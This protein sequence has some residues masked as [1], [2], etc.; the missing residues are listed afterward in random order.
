MRALTIDKGIFLRGLVITL[1]WA[2]SPIFW[3]SSINP[4]YAAG[5]QA[6][7]NLGVVPSDWTTIPLTGGPDQKSSFYVTVPLVDGVDD[8]RLF[9]YSAGTPV[10]TLV[11]T[12]TSSLPL[13]EAPSPRLWIDANGN[14]VDNVMTKKFILESLPAGIEYNF[15]I[16]SIDPQG[17]QDSEII[18]RNVAPLMTRIR[19]RIESL[20]QSLANLGDIVVVNGSNLDWINRNQ[21]G[22]EDGIELITCIEYCEPEP[23]DDPILRYITIPLADFI[24][25]TSTKITFAL[26]NQLPAG[27]QP[28]ALWDVVA[29][30]WGASG[31]LSLTIGTSSGEILRTISVTSGPNGAVTPGTS[32]T[33]SDGSMALYTITPD[34]GYE[35]ASATLNGISILDSLTAVDGVSKSYTF[36]SVTRNHSLEATFRLPPENP[37][38]NLQDEMHG[39]YEY[40]GDGTSQLSFFQMRWAKAS[41]VL[42]YKVKVTPIGGTPEIYLFTSSEICSGNFCSARISGLS[43]GPDYRIEVA[44]VGGIGRS[45]S[46]YVSRLYNNDAY[47]SL[48]HTYFKPVNISISKLS[49]EPGDLVSITG[50]HLDLA[51]R[52]S[53]G[54]HTDESLNNSAC[55]V[56]EL[57]E[58][59]CAEFSIEASEFL[60]VSPNS[61]S[62]HIPSSFPSQLPTSTF[63]EGYALRTDGH[64]FFGRVSF[65]LTTSTPQENLPTTHTITVNPGLHGSISPITSSLI[66]DGSTPTYTI[67]PENGYVIDSVTVNSSPISLVTVSGNIKSYTFESVTADQVIEAFF[68]VQEDTVITPPEIN[69]SVSVETAT[70]GTIT[71]GTLASIAPG[72][73]RTFT[74]TPNTGYRINTATLDGNNIVD[75]L[76]LVSGE[77]KS[78]TFDSINANHAI[79]ATFTAIPS[80]PSVPDNSSALQREA[81]A[82]AATRAAEALAVARAVAEKAEADAKAEAALVAAQVKATE[83]AAAEAA[84][85]AA[86]DLADAQAKATADAAALKAAR[87]LADAQA[88]AVKE[89]SAAALSEK[90][91]VPQIS[92]YSISASLK[93]N[94]Y[95]IGYLKKFASRLKRNSKV[96]CVGYIYAKNSTYAKAK[97][98]ALSQAEAACAL[99]KTEKKSISVSTIL[100]AAQDAP[101]AATGAQHLAVSYRVDAFEN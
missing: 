58:E 14:Y 67:T 43:T 79:S 37:P 21:Y 15:G 100:Y 93:L 51:Q 72:S 61:I 68:K 94:S 11:E 24:E 35:I 59:I 92:L 83:D 17:V 13:V 18:L 8:Y 36:E 95:S 77:I 88:K 99:I 27:A 66:Q 75:L 6:P 60:S 49:L 54:A 97:V 91:I 101:K 32:S 63:W 47:P 64:G 20:D 52:I 29:N 55:W 56:D 16:Q 86:R 1:L 31:S 70:N 46:I 90:K 22:N 50:A 44:S 33:I 62:F 81:E 87:D 28:G 10:E 3:I 19:P 42:E 78:Y 96:T 73:V 65:S 41:N 5:V 48:F 71:P 4:G 76:T 2:I 25:Q 38:T 12:L 26:P 39:E 53:F 98:K 9:V 89:L 34:A 40:V 30:A 84:L 74:F 80:V 23:M 85:K 7:I 57:E 69:F 82:L 45:D